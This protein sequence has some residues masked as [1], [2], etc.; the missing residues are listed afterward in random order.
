MGT[1][2]RLYCALMHERRGWQQRIHAQLFHQGAPPITALLTAAGREGLAGVEL[3]PAARQYLEVALAH[4]DALTTEIAPLRTQLVGFARN[5]RGC[6]TL[7]CH[8]GIGPLCAVIIWA[9]IGDG[10]RLATSGQLVRYAG[11]DVTVYSSAGKRSPGHLSRQGSAQLRWAALQAAK[12]AT[13]RGSPDYTYYPRGGRQTRR[14]T[15]HPG[16][17]TQAVAPVPSQSA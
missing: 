1:L 10:R 9:E 16:R 11:L 15:C 3:S 8:Y 4:I 6:Q 2:G 14:Q 12:S 5:Q 13:H 7:Q 17:G